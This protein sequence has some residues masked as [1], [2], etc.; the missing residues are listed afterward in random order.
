MRRD[1]TTRR[2]AI[3]GFVIILLLADAGLAAYSWELATAPW[4]SDKESE[5]TALQLKMLQAD[6]NR[7][8]KIKADMPNIQKDCEKFEKS[9]LAANSGS[10]SLSSELGGIAKKSG[11]RLDD[12]AFKPTV[13]PER[14]MM[15][16]AIDSTITGDYKSVIAFLNG[17][18]RS[19][20][21]YIVESLTLA[22]DNSNQGLAN[23]IKV[24]LHLKTYLRT[25]A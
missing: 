9:L 8:Q 7:A 2:R 4:A 18:Q 6:I 23:V 22:T 19:N 10:S 5:R 25:T 3:L 11:I 20:N 15:E 1:F 24:G 13:I 12:L 16:V 21:N 14:G 17:L